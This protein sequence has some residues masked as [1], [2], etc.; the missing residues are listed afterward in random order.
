MSSCSV[1]AHRDWFTCLFAHH[2]QC[3]HAY[4]VAKAC[5]CMYNTKCRSVA[6]LCTSCLNVTHHTSRNKT[7]EYHYCQFSPTPFLG[8]VNHQSHPY[9]LCATSASWPSHMAIF[10]SYIAAKEVHITSSTDC[11]WSTSSGT[12]TADRSCHPRR[13]LNLTT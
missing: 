1:Y 8:E 2:T 9:F 7:Y 11:F 5:I 4:I 3:E 10:T 12:L 13:R 6:V